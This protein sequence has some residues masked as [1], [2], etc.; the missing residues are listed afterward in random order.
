MGTVRRYDMDMSSGPLFPKIVRFSVPLLLSLVLQLAFDAADMA[1]IGN[2]ASHES[3]AAIGA[4]NHITTFLL[5]LV[6]GVAGG[7]NVVAAQR[8]GA[9]DR[10]G[11]SRTVHTAVALALFSGAVMTA[12]GVSAARSLLELTR[13]PPDILARACLY[14]RLRFLGIPFLLLYSFGSVLMRA[15]GDT[16]RPLYYL[17]AAGA[18]NL[19]LNLLLVVVFRMDVAGVA[20]ATAVSK[21]LSAYLVLRALGR[22]RGPG[23]LILS[24]VRFYGSELGSILRIG[25]PSGL[26]SSCFA[27]SNVIIQAAI[28]SFGAAAIAGNTAS[29]MLEAML[30]TT[31]AAMYQATLSFTGQNFGARRYD[32][33][34]RSILICLGCSLAVSIVLGWGACPVGARLLG[35]FNDHPEVVALGM[36]RLRI[37]FSTHFLAGAMDIVSGGLRGMGRSIAPAI[38][39]LLGACAFRIFWLATVFQEHRS[40]AVLYS[41]YPV[42]WLIVLGVNGAVLYL[43]CRRL[44]R[45]GGRSAARGD[46]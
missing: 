18:V 17:A 12:V 9:G 29:V 25:I 4:T 3:L 36:I 11:M 31:T 39:T 34:V 1:V 35:I 33:V 7:A 24:R 6:L 30:H 2:F 5:A 15:V 45:R 41:S 46:V 16:R 32:R 19:A 43:L 23:R 44:P 10:R 8:Y 14:L 27:L 40:L 37:M 20:L 22:D 42:S 28:N 38:V 26:Q 13:T 21:S